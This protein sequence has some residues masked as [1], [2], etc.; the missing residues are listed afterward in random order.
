[1]V[2]GVTDVVGG[3]VGGGAPEVVV[4]GMVVTAAVGTGDVVVAAVVVA[5]VVVAAVVVVTSDDVAPAAVDVDVTVVGPAVDVTVTYGAESADR[6]G[7]SDRSWS[8]H[9]VAVARVTT[10]PSVP[11]VRSTR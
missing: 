4:V 2:V 9:P 5:A 7:G 3:L 1:M 10:T 11:T 6:V 8:A